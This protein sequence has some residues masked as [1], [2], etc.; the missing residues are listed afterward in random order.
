MTQRLYIPR[1]GMAF[2]FAGLAAFLLSACVYIFAVFYPFS[3]SETRAADLGLA[4][5]GQA[6]EALGFALGVG[7]L[8][9][10]ALYMPVTLERSVVTGVLMSIIVTFGESLASGPYQGLVTTLFTLPVTLVWGALAGANVGVLLN[11][12]RAIVIL[13]AMAAIGLG[14]YLLTS[15]RVV[16]YNF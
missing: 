11:A 4:L 5:K 12:R 3:A 8:R 10:I 16:P 2:F 13:P 9:W 7:Y 6:G 1:S 14:Y 15:L